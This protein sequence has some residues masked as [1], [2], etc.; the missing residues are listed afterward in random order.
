MSAPRIVRNTDRKHGLAIIVTRSIQAR[1]LITAEE[2]VL[3][4]LLV[5]HFPHD[6]LLVGVVPSAE[7][8]LAAWIGRSGEPL[9]QVQRRSRKQSR[10][11]PIVLERGPQRYLPPGG[12]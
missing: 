6:D 1:E 2:Q 11:D 7:L 5:V 12:V 4:A 8:D 3:I 10:I 9:H